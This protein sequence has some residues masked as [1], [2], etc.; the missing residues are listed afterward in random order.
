MAY[1]V[2]SDISQLTLASGRSP[3]LDTLAQLKS[4]LPSAYTVFHGVHWTREYAGATSYGEIDFVVINLSGQVLF[5]EQKNGALEE[6]EN[7]LV[8][9]Y[10]NGPKSV[11][12]QIHR[13]ID[14]V[15]DKF[16]WQH[17]NSEKLDVEYLLYCP[18]YR[19]ID[20]SASG[21]DAARIVDAQNSDML[22]ST[23]ERLLGPGIEKEQSR[24]LMVEK[25]FQQTFDVVPDIHAHVSAQHKNFTRLRGGLVD[26]ISGLEMSPLKFRIDGVAGSGK[27]AV[28]RMIF[29]RALREGK[30]PLFACFNRPLAE[31]MRASVEGG[32]VDTWYGICAKFLEDTGHQIDYEKM[33]SDPNF[34]MGVQELV[35][36]Q[37]KPDKWYFDTLVV[38]EGQDFQ[39][40]WFDLLMTF[41]HDQ[42]DVVWL[43]DAN[44]NIRAEEGVELPADFLGY[45]CKT[46][47]RT[48]D[49]IARFMRRNF[50]IEFE[51]GNDL[52]GLGV[53]VER[54]DGTD[55]QEALASS[56][57]EEHLRRGF[58]SDDIVVVS[59]KGTS[60]AFFYGLDKI[61]AFTI[62]RFSGEYDELGNQIMSSG[63]ITC[64]SI[65]RFKGQ[66]APAVILVDVDLDDVEPGRAERLLHAGMTRATVRLDILTKRGSKI[67]QSIDL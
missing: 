14:K 21:L 29:E 33:Y 63:L 50:N 44:Q 5:I 49:T 25:F 40:L 65:Y 36:D 34:W 9:N 19:V 18:D 52:P 28:A 59:L 8:K 17:R 66:Q 7:G 53:G 46:N 45:H 1:I 47:Y 41:L 55:E 4:E 15:R 11:V 57:V 48:P 62:R 56:I 20:V 24:F 16:G 54:F 42:A 32:Y 30:R 6:T 39:Q 35:L 10:E 51:C 13:S 60:K 31:K 61:G 12:N 67:S 26:L 2:P 43:Q 27:S 23:I 64:E 22:A 3:E 37:D 38:D 58:E